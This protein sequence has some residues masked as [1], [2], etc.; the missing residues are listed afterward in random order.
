MGR[1]RSIT[2]LKPLLDRGFKDG[3]EEKNRGTLISVREVISD[4]RGK[5][6]F[7][8]FFNYLK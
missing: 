3:G 6:I 1:N 7:C 4:K 8:L 2:F 5:E